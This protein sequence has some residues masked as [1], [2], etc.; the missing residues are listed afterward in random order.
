MWRAC[1]SLKARWNR[2]V[3]VQGGFCRGVREEVMRH[4]EKRVRC[5]KGQQAHGVHAGKR[6]R[7]PGRHRSKL[8][9]PSWHARAR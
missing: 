4:T 7:T 8:T 6:A 5:G 3:V 1:L 2:E 9:P